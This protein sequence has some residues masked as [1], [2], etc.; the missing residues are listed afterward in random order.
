M[1]TGDKAAGGTGVRYPSITVKASLVVP[2]ASH[3][4]GTQKA[5]EGLNV[6]GHTVLDQ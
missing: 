4:P 2:R 3:D 1:S 6:L 5:E